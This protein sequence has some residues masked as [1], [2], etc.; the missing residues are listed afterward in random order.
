MKERT[1][2][3]LYRAA[4]NPRHSLRLSVLMSDYHISEK[5]LR[6]DIASIINFANHDGESLVE[7][8]GHHIR[9]CEPSSTNSRTLKRML[10]DMNLYEYHLSPDERQ[11]LIAVEL[12]ELEQGE[13]LT[14]QAIADEFYCSHN[15]IAADVK[16]AGAFLDRCGIRLVGK[17]S[18]GLR[19]EATDEQRRDIIIGAFSRI[20]SRC[21]CPE[22]YFLR[23][24][25]DHLQYKIHLD[26]VDRSVRAFLHSTNSY[27]TID[28]EYE[29]AATLA[30]LLNEIDVPSPDDSEATVDFDPIGNLVKAVAMDMGMRLGAGQILG[31]ER[32]ILGRDMTPQI[33]RFDDFD[34]YCAVSHFLMLVGKDLGVDLQSDDL[35]V[36]ALFSHI[37]GSPNWDADGFELDV[38]GE[39]DETNELVARVA[40]ACVPRLHII[41]DYL[42]RPLGK[43]MQDSIVIH[44]CAALY[45]YESNVRVCNVLVACPSSAATGRYLDAQV[46]AYFKFNVLGV[47]TCREV[48]EGVCKLNNVDFVI[49][50]VPIDTDKV[51]VVNVSPVLSVE[52]INE[53]QELAFKL[54]R[55]KDV[56]HAIDNTLVARLSDI[57][58][59]GN[60][61]KVAYLDREL[62]RILMEVDQV[63]GKTKRDSI[64][65]SNLRESFIQIEEDALGW[66]DAIAKVSLPLLGEGYVTQNYINRAIA[67]VE[68][69]GTYIIISQGIALA[70]AASWDGAL[71]NGL[72]LL[73]CK[74]GITFDEGE[75]VSLMFFSAQFDGENYLAMFREINKLGSDA[76]GF[77]RLRTSASTEEV[78]RNL[79]EILSDYSKGCVE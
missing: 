41:E 28:A 38:S 3:I 58:H 2:E 56:P 17:S 42:R 40:R 26:D 61:N 36:E 14:V 77:E 64:L 53:I 8:T 22:N 62:S 25:E 13:W 76:P 43:G 30:V 7:L 72:G 74:G 15:T 71:K 32:A 50:T 20:L 57:Y 44:V 10:D 78:L 11:W 12:L 6:A 46:K 69:Y 35:L 49:S 47:V 79:T 60:A 34:L 27:I 39:K 33:S 16:E 63:E 37:K 65:I 21:L 73:V 9:V 29:I 55:T 68:E 45:R 48:E 51:R 24:L 59:E 67:N 54:S 4:S 31:I 5:T 66:K 1:V 23:V 19:A 52:D 70:H 18:F 75:K